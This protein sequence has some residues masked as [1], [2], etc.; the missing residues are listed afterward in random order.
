MQPKPKEWFPL[1]IPMAEGTHMQDCDKVEELCHRLETIVTTPIDGV[2]AHD[3]LIWCKELATTKDNSTA[4]CHGTDHGN[5]GPETQ[6]KCWF[7]GYSTEFCHHHLVVKAA[8]R[9]C[10]L[11]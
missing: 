9:K 4:M 1:S 8:L 6:S 2:T 5:G 10:T 11:L 3:G 7:L